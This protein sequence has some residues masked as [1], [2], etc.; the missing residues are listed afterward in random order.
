MTHIYIPDEKIGILIFMLLGTIALCMFSVFLWAFNIKQKWLNDHEQIVEEYEDAFKS[1]MWK[2]FAWLLFSLPVSMLMVVGASTYVH[3]HPTWRI[4]LILFTMLVPV[5]IM[6]YLVFFP[7]CKLGFAIAK[8]GAIY[9]NDY[10]KWKYPLK[11][12]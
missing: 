10:M 8:I 4:S 1:A 12:L 6:F 2:I 5:A 7:L 9:I 3:L 11:Y